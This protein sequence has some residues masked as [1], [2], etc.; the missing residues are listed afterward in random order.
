MSAGPHSP[1]PAVRVCM[2][3]YS[4][5]PEAAGGA[6][7]QCRLQ[8]L[9]LA[10]LGHE[11]LVLTTRRH[12]ATPRR[13]WDHGCEV[14]RFRTLE[15]WLSRFR[16][17][18]REPVSAPEQPGGASVSSAAKGLASRAARAVRGLNALFFML[19]AGA[20]LFRRRGQIDVLHV[21]GADW[22]AG[23]AGWIGHRLS[24]PVVCKGANVPVFP[25]LAGIPFARRL[26]AWRRRV[27]YIA[28]T[29]AMRDD[30]MAH[31]VPGGSIDIIPNGV[32][33]P[34]AGPGTSSESVVLHVANYTQPAWNKAFDVLFGAW[35]RV[36]R[37]CP[38]ARLV[39]AG[40][41]DV[42]AWKRQLA[43]AGCA[44]P[45][46]FIGYRPDLE[47]WFRRA[48]VF[49]LPSRHEGISN[50]L[51]EAQGFGLPAVVS[52]IPGNRAVVV[53]GE[54]GLVVPAGDA[55]ALARALVQLLSNPELRRRLGAAARRRTAA[56]F[57]IEA[58]ARKL[59]AVL[60]RLAAEA[61]S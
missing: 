60:G 27:R 47:A 39:S 20:V 18:A 2:L 35:P 34:A 53:D 40:A 31:G 33:I 51:L 13:E 12:P 4:Y 16:P 8:A 21:H 30:L 17:P 7:R 15:A 25:P 46:D 50:A 57:G 37:E 24:I 19:G 43:E 41:G 10:R 36:I 54:T 56:E 52:D 38:E 49:V 29:P 5:H 55:E 28:L 42:S 9:A 32:E 59:S 58:V 14:I 11:C 6:E 44:D 48:A 1:G 23:F 3:T 26:E 61:K 22:H 45:V